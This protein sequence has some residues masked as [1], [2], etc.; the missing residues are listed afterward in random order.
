[1]LC[2]EPLEGIFKDV[3]ILVLIMTKWNFYC[4]VDHLI[5]KF[6]L[7][8]YLQIGVTNKRRLM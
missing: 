8:V 6:I 1:M 2:E 7:D 5:D 4:W 3:I